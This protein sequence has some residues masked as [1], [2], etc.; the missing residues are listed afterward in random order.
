MKSFYYSQSKKDRDTYITLLGI[1]GSLSKLFSNSANPYL[2]YRTMENI[3][4]KS[5]QANNLSRNDISADASKKSLGIGLKT[6]LH[7][8]GNTIQKIAEFNKESYLLKD[9]KKKQLAIRLG[10]LRNKRLRSTMEIAEIDQMIYHLITRVD[11]R[12]NIYEEAIDFIDIDSIEVKSDNDKSL[13]FQDRFHEYNFNKSKST[14][15]KRFITDDNSFIDFIPINIMED[16]YEALLKLAEDGSIVSF[17]ASEE[18]IVDYIVLPL[19]SGSSALVE[20][21]SGLNMWN[22]AGR[23]RNPDEVYIPIPRWIHSKKR[24]FFDYKNNTNNTDSFNVTL[25]NNKVL[26]M[27]VVQQG[28]K[29]LSSN[30]NKALGK[31]ILRDVLNI[32]YGQIVRMKDLDEIGVDSVQLSKHRDGSYSLDFLKSG[33]FERYKE[34][35][36]EV[37]GEE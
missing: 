11:G 35:I 16:P 14:L 37:E 2:H 27:K 30:P 32:P 21:K 10:E 17:V 24:D 9:L 5:F 34:V 28:G 26:S 1:M 7:N 29:G 19:Y 22:A 15:M 6:F 13:V 4:C 33:S 36:F 12:F 8:N 31:W 3:F 18:T 20:E 23:K 25:P